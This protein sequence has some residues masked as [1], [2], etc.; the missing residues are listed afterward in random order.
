MSLRRRHPQ[1]L[2]EL[3]GRPVTKRR[4][5]P[6][7][8]VHA[9]EEMRDRGPRLR[10]IA[11]LLPMHLFVF[12]RLHEGLAGSIVVRIPFPAHADGDATAFQ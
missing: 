12:E 6:F 1:V 8:V 10:Q 3:Q 4:V 2:F 11:V 9:L 7:L 5:E